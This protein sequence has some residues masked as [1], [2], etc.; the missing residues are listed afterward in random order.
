M[1]KK[2]FDPSTTSLEKSAPTLVDEKQKIVEKLK[3]KLSA[4][5][6]AQMRHGNSPEIRQQGPAAT[7]A[8][9]VAKWLE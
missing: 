1:D 8:V 4:T 2:D 3:K 5:K 7:G 6:S 9:V